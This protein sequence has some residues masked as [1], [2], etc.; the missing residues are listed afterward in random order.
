M[1]AITTGIL[2]ALECLVAL[3]VGLHNWIPLGALNDV[4]AAKAEFPGRKL[5][6]VTLINFV[7]VAVGL[8]GSAIY[9]ARVYPRWLLWWLWI[10]YWLVGCGS[11]REWW[12]PYFSRPQPERVTRHQAM[13]GATHSFLPE[14]NGIRPNTLHVL[15]DMVTIAIFIIL[16]LVTAQSH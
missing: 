2:L 6:T 3:F 9:L 16:G 14:R 4:K 7:P 12:I 11:L 15:F 10:F 13:Y 5:F 1:D 8:L